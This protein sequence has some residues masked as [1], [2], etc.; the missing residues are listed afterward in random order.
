MRLRKSRN[1]AE[2]D[3]IIL[4]NKGYQALNWLKVDYNQKRQS[5]AF[6][7]TVDHKRYE[8]IVNEWGRE[9][10]NTLNSIFPTELEVNQFLHPPHAFGAIASETQ[11]D[12]KAGSLR[13]RLDDLLKGLDEIRRNGLVR[14][15][16]LPITARLYIEDIDSFAK[17]RDVN[18]TVI[19]H[20]LQRHGYLDIAEDNI[21]INLEKILNEPFHKKDWGGEYND[22]YTSN[23]VIN[24]ARRAAAF[25]LKG[26]GLQV[27]HMEIKHCGKNGDQLLRLFDSPAELFIVQFVG[28]VSEAV[29]K[30]VEGKV[31]QL[32]AKGKVACYCIINGQD[33]A[34]L[35][36]AYAL[37]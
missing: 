1:T 17:V 3:L 9:V 14:Y 16:D 10:T 25:L 26:N 30:D 4:L 33:T 19:S 36:H 18:P 31:D 12:Y 24:G 20:L 21:Q 27:G 5:G 6:N 22:L 15:T 13:I 35:L 34:R 7:S 32:R 2:E 28:N 23:L 8:D 37:L 29:I 11:D